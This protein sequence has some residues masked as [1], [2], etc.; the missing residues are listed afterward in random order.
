MPYSTKDSRSQLLNKR[1][2]L[3]LYHTSAR[4]PFLFS[5]RIQ[6]ISLLAVSYRSYEHWRSKSGGALSQSLPIFQVPIFWKNDHTHITFQCTF[7]SKH[8]LP[9]THKKATAFA[10]PGFR[11]SPDPKFNLPRKPSE[12]HQAHVYHASFCTSSRPMPFFDS[13]CDWTFGNLYRGST[14]VLYASLLQRHHYHIPQILATKPKVYRFDRKHRV[15]TLVVCAFTLRSY[16]KKILHALPL[17]DMAIPPPL[18]R[19]CACYQALLRPH[20]GTFHCFK[21]ICTLTS[22]ALEGP[23]GLREKKRV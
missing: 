1:D 10:C 23:H 13:K 21:L 20:L 2:T 15:G 5:Y 6:L 4:S 18:P 16:P 22:L 9:V 19:S 3:I 14:L 8:A 12:K 11:Q 7:L 17:S